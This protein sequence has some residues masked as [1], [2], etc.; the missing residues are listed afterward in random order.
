MSKPSTTPAP[1]ASTKTSGYENN[2]FFV[3]TNGLDLLFKRAQSIGILTAI[4]AALSVLG[5]LPSAFVQ[6]DEPSRTTSAPVQQSS[7][8]FPN[9]PAEVWLLVAALALVFILVFVAVGIIVRGVLDYT[10]ASLANDKPVTI[11]EAFRAVFQNFWSYTWVV[12]IASLKT[13]LWS[14]LFI[15]PGIIMSV[16]YSLAGVAY[17]DKQLKGDAAVKHSS[18][19]VKGAWLTTFASQNLLNLIT[20]GIIQPLLVPGTNGILYRQ[21]TAAGGTKPKAHFL[22]WL[23]LILPLLLFGIIIATVF[24]LAW[25][26]INYSHAA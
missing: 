3:A 14:L 26:L 10:S 18:A 7:E 1:K 15:I 25:A 17:F 12:F 6:P 9:I 24:F 21:L 11:S 22:S 23:T 13:L 20:L 4:I 5:S 19:L 16:R 2:P 8:Q